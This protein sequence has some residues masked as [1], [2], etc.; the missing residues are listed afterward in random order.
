MQAE[1]LLIDSGGGALSIGPASGPTAR[2][3]P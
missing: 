2:R 3:T 1:A